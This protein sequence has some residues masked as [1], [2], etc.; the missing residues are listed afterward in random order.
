MSKRV[1]NKR[2]G[3]GARSKPRHRRVVHS[4]NLPRAPLD[5]GEYQ[6]A[7]AGIKPVGLFGRAAGKLKRLFRRREAK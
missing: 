5:L 1:S 2:G 4:A 6:S 7:S 3:G